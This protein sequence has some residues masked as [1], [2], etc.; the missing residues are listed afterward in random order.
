VQ[1]VPSSNLGGP[2]K[3][4]KYLQTA[5]PPDGAFGVQLESKMD[6]VP[7]TFREHTRKLLK[8]LAPLS[9]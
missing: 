9:S 2:T 8:S 6:A 1:E 7:P 4:L 5:D 3:F